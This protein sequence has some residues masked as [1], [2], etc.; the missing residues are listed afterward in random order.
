MAP[1][2][3][4]AR[5]SSPVDRAEAIHSRSPSRCGNLASATPTPPT[6]ARATSCRPSGASAGATALVSRSATLVVERAASTLSPMET[7]ASR[8][9]RGISDGPMA[10]RAATV[11]SGAAGDATTG[12]SHAASRRPWSGQSTSRSTVVSRRITAS[13][14]LLSPVIWL[15]AGNSRQG[16]WG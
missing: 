7:P 12:F 5:S 16:V 2:A 4:P 14:P 10:S 6:A 9:V 8:E 15:F 11:S 1:P 3:P 13:W